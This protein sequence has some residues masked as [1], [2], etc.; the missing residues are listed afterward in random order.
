MHFLAHI[1][2]KENKVSYIVIKKENEFSFFFGQYRP[3]EIILAKKTVE[4]VLLFHKK[5]TKLVF[6]WPNMSQKMLQN[7]NI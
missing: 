3:L 1:G 5:T 2:P 6:L 7:V 4:L